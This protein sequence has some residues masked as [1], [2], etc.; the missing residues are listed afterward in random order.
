[1]GTICPV[2]TRGEMVTREGIPRHADFQSFFGFLRVYQ[3]ITCSVL[4]APSQAHQD[5]ILAHSILFVTRQPR[6]PKNVTPRS[7]LQPFLAQDPAWR[8]DS[9]M[10]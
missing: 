5:T 6:T 7:S 8:A 9:L 2:R 1:M 3:S 10:F 4:P